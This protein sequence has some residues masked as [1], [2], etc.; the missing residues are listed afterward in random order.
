MCYKAAFRSEG[1]LLPKSSTASA[2]DAT[3]V[4][5][6]K[7]VEGKGSAEARTVASASNAILLVMFVQKI[8]YY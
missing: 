5:H 1:E 4:G 3:D 6:G 2:W 7:S 8:V